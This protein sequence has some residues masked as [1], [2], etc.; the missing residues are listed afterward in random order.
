MLPPVLDALAFATGTPL[1]LAECELILKDETGSR[2]R[3]AIYVGHKKTP[4]RIELSVEAVSETTR[5]LENDGPKLSICWHRYALYRQLAL[6]QFV[7]HWLAFEA[8]AG[9]ADIASRCPKCQEVVEHCGQAVI[10]RSSSRVKAAE[11]F[12]SANPGVSPTEF[13]NRIWSKARNSVFHGLKYPEPAYLEE[14][15]SLSVS[16]RKAAEKEIAEIMGLAP[17]RPYYRYEDLFRLF[18][19]VEWNTFDL[20]VRFA[21]DWPQAD[22]ARRTEMLEL[23]RVFV[24]PVNPDVVFLNYVEQSPNW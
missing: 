13:K 17:E 16:L 10:H 24:E 22:L 20:H 5:I 14:L 19:F 9:D 7:F 3:R 12:R 1:L 4:S 23:G 18:L 15:A 6:D 2:P 11:I 8:L 21:P